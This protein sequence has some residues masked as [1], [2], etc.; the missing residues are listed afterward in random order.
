MFK[1]T[2]TA[3]VAALTMAGAV[4]ASSQPAEARGLGRAVAIGAAGFAVGALA[5]GAYARPVYYGGGYGGYGYG[6]GYVS[7][8]VYDSWGYQVGYRSV[9]AC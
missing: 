6:C 5:A 9:P 8:P 2:L 1:K 4:A 7:R 3:T